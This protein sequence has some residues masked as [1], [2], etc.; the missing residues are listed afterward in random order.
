[1]KMTADVWM[2]EETVYLVYYEEKNIATILDSNKTNVYAV[3]VSLQSMETPAIK[4]E[5]E[6]HLLPNGFYAYKE[7]AV[8]ELGLQ[9]NKKT[10]AT[11]IKK[12]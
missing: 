1:M 3:C 9:Q 12:Y 4:S 7:L 8:V 6:T 10:A 2:E 5:S 11:I